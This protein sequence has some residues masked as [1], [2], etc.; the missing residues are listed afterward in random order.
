M[1][2]ILPAKFISKMPHIGVDS[3]SEI[4]SEKVKLLP[5]GNNSTTIYTPEAQNKILFKIPAYANSFMNNEAGFLSFKVKTTGTDATNKTLLGMGV[6]VF[7]RCVIK[8]AQ[9]LIVSEENNFHILNRL[10]TIHRE[11]DGMLDEGVYDNGDISLTAK[12]ATFATA[13]ETGITYIL[14]FK[15]SI[16]AT[17]LPYI[18]LFMCDSVGGSAFDI[19]LTLSRPSDCLLLQTGSASST[20]S[21]E[22]TE[23]TLNLTILRMSP[24]LTAKYHSI[25]SNENEKII[26]PF[27]TYRCHTSSLTTATKQQLSIHEMSTNI[28]KIWTVLT[29]T[30]NVIDSAQNLGFY[31]AVK[32]TDLVLESYNY[33]VGNQFIYNEPVNESTNNNNNVTLQHVKDA[34]FSHDKKTIFSQPEST[35]TLENCFE[36]NSKKMFHT[37]CGFDYSVESKHGVVQGISSSTPIMVSITVDRNPQQYQM[38]NFCEIGYNLE[39][40]HGSIRY[41]EQKSG[42]NQVY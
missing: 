29:K 27:K 34:S 7:S 11:S 28:K 9:G 10:F 20:M 36:S 5:Y 41:V 18:P 37:V 38:H 13:L 6:P 26:I 21:Y 22:I 19:E 32:D 15:S 12:K 40:M 16:M 39:S 23:P 3:L 1:S 14:K 17:D 35:T 33:Q 42:S 31:G 8:S 4:K 25:A 2:K 30:H 24:N